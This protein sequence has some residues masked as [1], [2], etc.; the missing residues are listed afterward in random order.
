MNVL[1]KRN[2]FNEVDVK[3]QLVPTHVHRHNA[4]ERAMRTAKNHLITG[5][6]LCDTIFPAK[7]WDRL[8]PQA[9]ITLNLLR[10]SRCN[11]SLLAYT[12]VWG[13]FDFNSTPLTSPG[14]KTVVHLKPTK[15]GTFQVHA[16]DGWY[17]GPSMFH[18]RCFKKYIP[19]TGGIRDADIVDFFPQQIPFL[20]VTPDT[21]LRQIAA[22]LLSILTSK[23]APIPELTYGDTY[24]NAFIKIAKILQRDTPPPSKIIIF[25]NKTP[26]LRQSQGWL[27]PIKQ[28]VITVQTYKTSLHLHF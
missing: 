13:D 22:D 27:K 9:Q 6:Y 14:T 16:I 2:A 11:P 10:A 1:T 28:N 23:K 21:Y 24:T 26:N 19:E 18:Y 15:R 25:Q 4:A 5:L 8:F 20:T 12:S 17:I 7:E 3:Y